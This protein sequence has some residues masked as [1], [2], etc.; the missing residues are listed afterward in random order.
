MKVKHLRGA[1]SVCRWAT[2]RSGKNASF[3]AYA[4][5]LASHDR[6][7]AIAI[8]PIVPKL[9]N[10]DY[11]LQ[12]VIDTQLLLK[13]MKAVVAQSETLPWLSKINVGTA[14]G[15]SAGLGAGYIMMAFRWGALITSGLATTFPVWQWIDPLPIL[16]S[17]KNKSDNQKDFGET[18]QNLDSQGNESLESIV[19]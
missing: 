7:Q 9:N 12:S 6:L 18:E 10:S 5:Y 2:L 1:S 14:I 15:I 16:E 11:S 17:S 19:S 4:D 13:E 8:Q 3:N